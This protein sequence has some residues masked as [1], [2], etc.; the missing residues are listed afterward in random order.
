MVENLFSGE[1]QIVSIIL[2]AILLL[3]I[4]AMA[5]IAFFYLSRKRITESEL[6]NANLQIAHQQDVLQSTL[7]TQEA[8]RK[9]IAQDLHDAISSKLNIV[10]LQANLL[11]E[12]AIS[13]EETNKI[14]Q[15]IL[16]VTTTVLESSRQI[17]HALL[18]PTLEKFGLDAALE[19][20][21]DE[22]EAAG[23]FEV[24]YEFQAEDNQLTKE[25][26]LHL[27]RIAQELSNNAIKYSEANRITFKLTSEEEH[28]QFNYTDDGKGM[29]LEEAHQARGLGMSGIQNRVRI[30]EGEVQFTSAP[31]EGFIVQIKIPKS[32]RE[33]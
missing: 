32:V 10:S 15:S 19:E 16:K 4:M 31:K 8:E 30:M 28:L 1:G 11:S 24:A 14:G 20:L 12:D 18:P 17:A 9:R 33:N 21:C 13:K 7:I 26:E 2:G 25:T 27:F 3:I 22:L 29:D 5:L 6:E 23:T